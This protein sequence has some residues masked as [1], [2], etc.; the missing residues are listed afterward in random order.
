MASLPTAQDKTPN[1][2]LFKDALSKLGDKISS[3]FG[4]KSKDMPENSIEYHNR[5]ENEELDKMGEGT[6]HSQGEPHAMLPE[7]GQQVDHPALKVLMAKLKLKDENEPSEKG[8]FR[9]M[10]KA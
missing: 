5:R 7:Q 9:G 8:G 3:M 2:N 10:K 1:D 4:G 6:P